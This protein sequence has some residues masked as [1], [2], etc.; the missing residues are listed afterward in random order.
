MSGAT[1]EHRLLA[2]T[3]DSLIHVAK[4]PMSKPE[5]VS[6]PYADIEKVTYMKGMMF[7]STSVWVGGIEVKLDKLG[8]SDGEKIAQHL[9][10]MV[11]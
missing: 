1:L 7:G 10:G 2:L 4:P 3:K 5:V 9:E 11:G 8:Q 6:I